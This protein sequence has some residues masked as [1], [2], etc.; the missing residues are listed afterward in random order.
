MSGFAENTIPLVIPIPTTEYAAKSIYY[1]DE[2][3]NTYA[4]RSDQGFFQMLAQERDVQ[5]LAKAIV[6][7][8]LRYRKEPNS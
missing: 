3:R 5:R 4:Y 7:Y 6:N 2:F 8:I 1:S